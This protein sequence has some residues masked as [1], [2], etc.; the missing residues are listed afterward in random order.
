MGH[1]CDG[2][3]NFSLTLGT[4]LKK[5]EQRLAEPETGGIIETTQTSS[6]QKSARILRRV[7]EARGDLLSLKL[8]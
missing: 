5:I 1:E 7:L 4:I 3:D 8:P 6:L 2:D